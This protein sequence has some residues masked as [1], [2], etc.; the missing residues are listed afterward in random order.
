MTNVRK[1]A[2]EAVTMMI[3]MMISMVIRSIHRHRQKCW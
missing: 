3:M 2:K 1:S